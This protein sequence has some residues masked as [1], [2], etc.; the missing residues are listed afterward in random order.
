MGGGGGYYG[1]V[2]LQNWGAWDCGNVNFI[3]RFGEACGMR[4]P[5]NAGQMSYRIFPNCKGL[6]IIARI[7]EFARIAG[8]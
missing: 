4:F 8:N 7:W 3:I 1:E 2:I 5:A 6:E